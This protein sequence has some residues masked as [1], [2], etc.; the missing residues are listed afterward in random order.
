M[1]SRRLESWIPSEGINVEYPY[2]MRSVVF[3]N[4][5]IVFW[6]RHQPIMSWISRWSPSPS[7]GRW[8]Q[9]RMR[10]VNISRF[11]MSTKLLRIIVKHIVKGNRREPGAG[12]SLVRA[13]LVNEGLLHLGEQRPL[14]HA[15]LV[16]VATSHLL[17]IHLQITG[18][19][20]PCIGLLSIQI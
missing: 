20:K 10:S 2:I 19:H 17:I 18:L 4:A 12:L 6:F 15:L 3:V 7:M 1:L 11:I 14:Y 16:Q 13:C 9:A 8:I 5:L